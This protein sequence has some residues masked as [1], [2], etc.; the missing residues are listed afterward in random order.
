MSVKADVDRIGNK[1]GAMIMNASLRVTSNRVVKIQAEVDRL[2]SNFF[3]TLAMKTIGAES[4]PSLGAYTPNWEDLSTSYTSR[5]KKR[6]KGFY[7]YTGR[8]RQSLLRS[9]ATTAFGKPLVLLTSGGRYRD[10]NVYVQN[11]RART[12]VGKF[13]SLESLRRN[14]S[15]QAAIIVD[16][17][18]TLTESLKRGKI[19]EGKYFSDNIAIKMTNYKGKRWRP[20]LAPYMNWWLEVKA[21]EAVRR[22]LR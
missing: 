12:V 22:G 15:I 3:T 16:I 20:I 21:R 18:P 5:K 6:G 7:Q 4:A 14:K 10:Q 2:Q 9:K 1:I 17:Y 8:L 13:V 11:N 19:D